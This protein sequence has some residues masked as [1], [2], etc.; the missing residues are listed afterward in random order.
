MSKR[1]FTISN[2]TVNLPPEPKM[3]SEEER[4]Q[5]WQE[6]TRKIWHQEDEQAEGMVGVTAESVDFQVQE[7]PCSKCGYDWRY[8]SSYP[9]CNGEM[10]DHIPTYFLNAARVKTILYVNA[11]GKVYFPAHADDHPGKG[12]E[13]KEI[14]TLSEMLKIEKKMLKVE[15][16]RYQVLREAEQQQYNQSMR[17]SV[18]ALNSGFYTEGYNPQTGKMERQFI[19]PLHRQ[20]QLVKDA[21]REAIERGE[22]GGSPANYEPLT[23]LKAAHFY[24]IK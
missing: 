17:E 2:L 22:K 15:R 23:I 18:D 16:E 4:Q 7:P 6:E 14:T 21:V 13:R 10:E 8:T 11:K 5:H 9:Y 3:K 12:Y 20:P 1:T 24:N 19:E